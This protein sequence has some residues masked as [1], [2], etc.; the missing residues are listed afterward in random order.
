MKDVILTD[1]GPKPIGPYSQANP[2]ERVLVRLGAVALDPKTGE[3]T[4]ADIKQQTER[5]LET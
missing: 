5:T 1:R 4:G 3:M 2:D